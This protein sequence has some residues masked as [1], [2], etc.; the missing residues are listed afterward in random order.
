M[1][2]DLRKEPSALLVVH[3]WHSHIVFCEQLYNLQLASA[4]RMNQNWVSCY[5]I[6]SLFLV[7]E[8][9]KILW[10][11]TQHALLLKV[12]NSSL[13]FLVEPNPQMQSRLLYHSVNR[14]QF[15]FL[16]VCGRHTGQCLAR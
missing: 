10:C 6:K 9:S 14:I 16:S 11:C 12:L 4:E 7:Q 15:R 1:P 3:L 13:W 5:R 2:L 8:L